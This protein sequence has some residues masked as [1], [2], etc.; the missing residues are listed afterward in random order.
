M[1]RLIPLLLL[2]V[3]LAACG[4]STSSRMSAAPEAPATPAAEATPAQ[5]APPSPPTEIAGLELAAPIPVDPAVTIGTLPNGLTYYVRPNQ[6]PEQRAA[7]F[8]VVSAG[9]VDEDDD[10]LGLAHM[11]EHMAF[12]G[13]AN[14]P[15]QALIDYLESLGMAFG[16]EINA[17]TN[18][19]QTVYMLQVPTDDVELL[20]KGLQILYE[21][22]HLVSFTDEEIDLERG[23]IIEEWRLGL[24]ADDRIWN[25]Q[26]PVLFKGSKYADRATIGDPEIVK[27]F[28]YDVIRRFYRDWYRPSLQAVL[29]VG[30][31][32]R[33]TVIAKIEKQ[34]ADLADPADPRPLEQPPVPDHDEIL[35]SV[36][37]DI[38]ATTTNVDITWKHEPRITET[39]SDWRENLALDLGMAMLRARF[40]E[41]TE[42]PDAPFTMAY[43]SD[44]QYTRT[45]GAFGIFAYVPENRAADAAAAL[46]TE[47]ERVRRH[48]FTTTELER[49]RISLLRR[50]ERRAHEAGKTESRRWCFQYM[51]HFLRDRPIPGPVYQYELASALLPTITLE[52]IETI[53]VGLM[54]DHNRV[55]MVSGPEK[56]GVAYPSEE[57][58]IAMT[59]TVAGQDIAPYE[60]K[61]VDQPLVAATPQPVAVT[62]RASDEALGTTTWTLANGVRVVLKPTDFKN[63]EV[64]MRAYGW[65]GT[66]AIADAAR[67]RQLAQAANIVGSSGVGAFDPVSLQKKL[68]GKVVNCWPYIYGNEEGFRGNASPQDLETLCQLVYLYATS[69]RED[70]EAFAA[71]QDRMRTWYGNRDVDPMNA[72]RDTVRVLVNG[73]DPRYA[74]FTIKDIDNADLSGSLELFRDRFADC[75]DFTFYFVGN[76]EPVAFEPLAATWLGNLPA[77]GRQDSWTDRSHELVRGVVQ[78]TV[79]KGLEPKGYVQMVF[80]GE[81]PWSSA[82][83]YA[84]ESLIA[85]LRIRLRKIIR[86]EKGGTYGVR[87]RG[88]LNR[89]PQERYRLDIG[90]GCD[91]ERTDELYESVQQVLADFRANGPDEETLTKVRETQLREDETNVQENRHWLRSLLDADMNETDPGHILKLADRVATLD[92]A[93]VHEAAKRY[94]DAENFVKVVLLPEG[95][96]SE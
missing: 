30:D 84:L 39:L 76:V 87:I 18:F 71:Y 72:L 60:D 44:H 74:P 83:E 4:S 13:T 81:A 54:T 75:G 19:N 48:G 12:N 64:Q 33:D 70:P 23:V 53:V 58:L 73:H 93:L 8:L 65:G 2:I 50:L 92:V 80:T 51:N 29:A 43:A 40:D 27:N 56:E 67:Y 6:K 79:A 89:I 35:A 21:W 57:A 55:L 45:K 14:F 34:F 32:D 3:T 46:L 22:A 11:A 66:S 1:M 59:A 63:D 17:F 16:P 88:S 42:K 90:W 95:E 41:I 68:T 24:G 9:S 25:A 78:Q 31:F 77:V 91:P 28:E 86:E 96:G 85:S 47:T 5:P 36:I 26:L 82:Q 49:A 7:L 69:P 52:E 15:E 61:T 37:T 10:Q 94:L 62:A 20:D 38:E